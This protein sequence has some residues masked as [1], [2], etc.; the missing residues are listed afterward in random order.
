MISIIFDKLNIYFWFLFIL[1][2]SMDSTQM[3]HDETTT[4]IK[5]KIY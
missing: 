4:L 1:I 3:K 2:I 5:G